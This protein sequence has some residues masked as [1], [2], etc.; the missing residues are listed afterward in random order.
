MTISPGSR[1]SRNNSTNT[2][3]STTNDERGG[4]LESAGGVSGV[5]VWLIVVHH[6]SRQAEC[7]RWTNVPSAGVSPYGSE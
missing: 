7:L 3:P 1:T 4:M 6:K 2:T 5:E